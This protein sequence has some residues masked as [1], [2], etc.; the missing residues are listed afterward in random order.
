MNQ[1]IAV[2]VS[3][4]LATVAVQLLDAAG[5]PIS[6]EVAAETIYGTPY[7]RLGVTSPRFR[8]RIT[9]VDATGWPVERVY[10]VLFRA[11][12]AAASR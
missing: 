2:H 10:P 3:G 4:E 6:E 11:Q 8:I 7:A 1:R 12:A 9:G 5:R